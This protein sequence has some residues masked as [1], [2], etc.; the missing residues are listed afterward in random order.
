MPGGLQLPKRLQAATALLP[1]TSIIEPELLAYNF[2]QFTSVEY[3]VALKQPANAFYARGLRQ[4]PFDLV[5]CV[6]TAI[7]HNMNLIVQNLFMGK[8]Q[9]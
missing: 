9:G 3:I 7:I 8:R 5:L 4:G 2:G 6:H 1:A